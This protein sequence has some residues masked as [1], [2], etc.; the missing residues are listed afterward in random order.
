MQRRHVAHQVLLAEVDEL[1]DDSLPNRGSLLPGPR[2][3]N[4]KGS[5]PSGVGSM[6]RGE[7]AA[8]KVGK[9]SWVAEALPHSEGVTYKRRGRE[10]VTCL[11]DWRM[12]S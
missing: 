9:V 1:G 4:G 5:G 11:R 3:R 7:R 6:A 12:G 8:V 10:V 2:T